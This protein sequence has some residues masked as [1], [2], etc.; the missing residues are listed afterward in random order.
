MT[1]RLKLASVVFVGVFAAAQ[2]IRPDRSNPATDTSRT[3]QSQMSTASGLVPVL[4]R[5]CSEC[6]SN[7]TV[8]PWYTRIAPVSWLMARGVMEARHAVNFSEWGS[9]S[10]D[11]Q[12]VLLAASCDAAAA[13]RMPGLY[14][15]VDPKAR[16][17]ADDVKT[18]CDAAR[19]VGTT[20]T[21][22]RRER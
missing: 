17:S 7:A 2:L 20:T 4:Q 9:Y 12:Q 22:A 10:P 1:R 3:I 19:Q 13:G 16:L 21:S 11:E 15:R 8:W 18:I 6:H 5:A 14:A